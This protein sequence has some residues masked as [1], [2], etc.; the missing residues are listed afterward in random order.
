VSNQDCG[1]NAFERFAEI[2]KQ[3]FPR[4]KMIVFIDALYAT[5]SVL[6]ILHKYHWGA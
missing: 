2:L 4:L 6:G 3:H 1:L 5:Q